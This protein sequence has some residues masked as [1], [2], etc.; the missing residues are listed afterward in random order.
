[1][2][3]ARHPIRPRGFTLIE[4]MVVIGIIVLLA[5][6]LM[7][8]VSRVRQQAFNTNTQS[9]M[10]R[11]MQA[12]E[13]YYHDFNAYPGPIPNSQLANV[14]GAKL[15]LT[16]TGGGSVGPITS[17]ENLVLGL[18][19]LLNP[20]TSGGAPLYNGNA[21][22]QTTVLPPAHDVLSLNP[23]HP[24]SYHYIDYVPEEL[25]TGSTPSGL[26]V[27]LLYAAGSGSAA[28][29]DTL[30]PEFVDRFSDPMPIIYTR[31][32]VGNP[33]F[34]AAYNSAAVTPAPQYNWLELG[35]YGSNLLS[36][37]GGGTWQL[38]TEQ[39]QTTMYTT[40]TTGTTWP[41]TNAVS[42]N[43]F[44]PSGWTPGSP[45]PAGNYYYANPNIAGSVRGKDGFILIDAG[46]DRTYGTLDDIILTP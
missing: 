17:S 1:M 36:S 42:Y 9:Q 29:T 21:T 26:T 30:V 11:I 14:I 37:Q 35:P 38:F 28:P 45:W 18:F 44:W 33:G 10:Q 6:I 7:P 39:N 24:A 13:S 25:S 5:A 31:A 23:L 43:D 2:Q 34:A 8:V 19:G 12:C 3:P 41:D 40:F 16:T 27:N 4:L 22:A 32:Y 15:T 20:Q 46:L